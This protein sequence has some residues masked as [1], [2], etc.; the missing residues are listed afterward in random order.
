L[1]ILLTPS[2]TACLRGAVKGSLHIVEADRDAAVELIQRY[3]DA[4][5]IDHSQTAALYAPN[6]TLHYIGRHVLG[7][8]YRGAE[9]ILD[10][11]RRSRDAFHGT[12][13]LELHDVVANDRHAIALLSGSAEHGGN[14]LEWRRVV[15]FHIQDGRIHEQWIH[16]SDQHVIEEALAP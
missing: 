3:F 7:G 10:L 15:V 5:R 16:D 8:V 2:V 6:A 11:F 13:R 9:E 14:R 4:V 12:Q 1:G